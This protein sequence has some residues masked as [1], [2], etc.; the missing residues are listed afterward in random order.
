MADAGL[1][2]ISRGL[3]GY[4]V[5]CR[6]CGKRFSSKSYAEIVEFMLVHGVVDH[7]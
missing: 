4:T 1:Y 7:F 6:R 2:R 5:V 3:W